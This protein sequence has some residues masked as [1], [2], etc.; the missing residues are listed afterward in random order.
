MYQKK[1]VIS[2]DPGVN[3]A[4]VV[5]TGGVFESFK[6]PSTSAKVKEL[7]SNYTNKYFVVV[8][9]VTMFGS[10]KDNYKFMKTA[11]MVANFKIL[12]YILEE[13]NFKVFKVHANTWQKGLN[14]YK[15]NEEYKDR[16]ERLFQIAK[17]LF[18]KNKVYKYA[19]DAFLINMY[20]F[21]IHYKK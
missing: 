20:Y 5:K 13:L 8:E 18:H 15:K 17:K 7:L 9:N 4:I 19:A 1:Y 6:M 2:I 21:H 16:K 12:L 3:G 11:E 14:F 10:D